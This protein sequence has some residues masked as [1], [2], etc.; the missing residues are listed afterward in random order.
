[1]TN[2]RRPHQALQVFKHNDL[3]A[4]LQVTTVDEAASL[5]WAAQWLDEHREYTVT[6]I[7]LEQTEYH[8]DN[9]PGTTTIVIALHL[10]NMHEPGQLGPWTHGV[11]PIEL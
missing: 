8:D 11:P 7:K 4:E 9:D 5:M 6:D 2:S 10:A 3:N 1:M